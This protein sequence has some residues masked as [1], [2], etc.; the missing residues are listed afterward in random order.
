MAGASG[1]EGEW[2]EPASH[3]RLAYRLWR[4][5]APRALLVIVHGFAE[6]GGRYAVLAQMLADHGICVG[7]PDLWGHGRSGGS[8]G[9]LGELADCIRDLDGLTRSVFLPHAGRERYAVL[10]HSFGGLAAVVWALRA[11]ATFRRLIVQS[12]LIDV[13]SPLPPW[14]TT[15]AWSLAGWWPA[16]P[17]HLDLDVSAL[18]HDPEVVEAYRRDPL[19]H[20]AMS[21]GTYRSLKRWQREVMARPAD[22]HAAVLL[23]CGAEDRVVSIEAARRWFDGLTGEKRS[24]VFPG[25]FHELHHEPVRDEVARLIAEWVL[26]EGAG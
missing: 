16:C 14:K 26:S 10:G 6:H 13:A 15:F 9:G 4:P 12:P 18:S 7:V 5:V 2:V 11:P 3:R 8:R 21:A 23:L 19:V 17:F 24:V 25:G 22:V 1:S 20:N